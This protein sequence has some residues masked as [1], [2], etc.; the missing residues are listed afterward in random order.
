MVR[1][2]QRNSRFSRNASYEDCSDSYEDCSDSDEDVS[3]TYEDSSGSSYEDCS[4]SESLE[5]YEDCS[6]DKLSVVWSD[7][8]SD[9]ATMKKVIAKRYKRR[10]FIII[11]VVVCSITIIAGIGVAVQKTRQQKD[12]SDKNDDAKNETPASTPTATS[13][14]Y[15]SPT[16]AMEEPP[17]ATPTT[18]QREPVLVESSASM[19]TWAPTTWFPTPSPSESF[20]S[21]PTLPFPTD[22]PT[23]APT[24]PIETEL[25]I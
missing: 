8:S 15:V 7:D 17:T 4:D 2:D 6:N 5:I 9:A 19:E 1:Q 25:G 12:K 20:T 24:N 10:I 21:A 18:S 11:A 23:V 16:V 14:D 13:L 3:I 22:S